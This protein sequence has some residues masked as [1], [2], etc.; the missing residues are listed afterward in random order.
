MLVHLVK[1]EGQGHGL[2]FT[3]TWAHCWD[4]RSSCSDSWKYRMEKQTWI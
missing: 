2:K 3:V 1:F 4:G